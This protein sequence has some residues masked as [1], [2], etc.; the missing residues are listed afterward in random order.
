MRKVFLLWHT[1]MI[2]AIAHGQVTIPVYPDS[3]FPAFYHQRESLFD[4]LPTSHQD[5]IFLGNSITNG[6][7]WTELF[8]NPL[9]KNRGISG[10]VTAGVLNRIDP[11]AAGHPAKVFLLIGINDLARNISTDS[12]LN[13]IY[14]IADI[15]RSR[16]RR[17]NC[18]FKV[19]CRSTIISIC[20]ITMSIRRIVLKQSMI[21]WHKMLGSIFIVTYLYMMLFVMGMEG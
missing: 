3:L 8:R 13:N 12:I 5:I 19:Y 6:A 2:M 7:E 21:N 18:M 20:L 4:I 16:S 9:C 17:Q 11:I 10:D 1:L 14:L 15:L